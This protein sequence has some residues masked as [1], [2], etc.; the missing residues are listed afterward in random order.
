LPSTVTQTEAPTSPRSPKVALEGLGDA[1][2]APRGGA[3]DLHD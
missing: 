1:L 3:V 2:E